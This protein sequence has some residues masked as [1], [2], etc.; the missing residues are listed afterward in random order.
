[1][2]CESRKLEARSNPVQASC[3]P[4][5]GLTPSSRFRHLRRH[6]GTH[7]GSDGSAT[8]SLD[9]VH[10][11][12]VRRFQLILLLLGL[13]FSSACSS[14]GSEVDGTPAISRS[15]FIEAYVDLRVA[16]LRIPGEELTVEARDRVLQELGLTEDDLI[17]F[18][19]V[20]GRDAQFM[21]RVWEEVD[22][23]ITEKRGLPAGPSQRGTP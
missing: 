9:P 2:K 10:G 18:I 14:D 12:S 13:L 6:F 7:A 20:H 1:M 11:P 8:A 23:I 16:A 4:V 15:D 3:R 21:R 22:S 17:H 5:P 19:E